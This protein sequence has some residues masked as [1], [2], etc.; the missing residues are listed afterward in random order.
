MTKRHTHTCGIAAM[1][2]IFGDRWTWLLV[3]EAFYGV[4]R[5][6]D[7]KRNTGASRNILT[8]RLAALVGSGVFE[9]VDV[10]IQG[11]RKEYFLTE[12]GKSL[13]PVMIA[14]G[15]WANAHEYGAGSEPVLQI[16]S[17]T[18]LPLGQIRFY[19]A[20]GTEVS[21]DKLVPVPGPGAS[22]ATIRRLKK[23]G[24]SRT[25]QAG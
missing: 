6:T 7:F 25:T 18:D 23:I 1:T 19:D 15:E 2:N 13:L 16:N 3:R 17:E 5:F 24:D 8:D 22:A 9:E 20:G 14:M 12:K 21:V 11:T 4:S 10:G